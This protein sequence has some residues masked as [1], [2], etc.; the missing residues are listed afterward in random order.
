MKK[1]WRKIGEARLHAV[2]TAFTAEVLRMIT[3]SMTSLK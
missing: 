1:G 2:C 3:I